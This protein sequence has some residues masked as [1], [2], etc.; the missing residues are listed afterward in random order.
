MQWNLTEQQ[1][2]L[3]QAIQRGEE[4]TLMSQGEAIAQVKAIPKPRKIQLGIMKIDFK[5][6][7]LEP[8]DQS[9]IDSFYGD[10]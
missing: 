5:S 7:L 3:I 8:T 2:E 4:V 9:M 6:D 10:N 1:S